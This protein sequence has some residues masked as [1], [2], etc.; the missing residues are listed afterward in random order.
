MVFILMEIIQLK[1]FFSKQFIK[2]N[3]KIVIEAVKQKNDTYSEFIL[4]MN[5]DKKDFSNNIEPIYIIPFAEKMLKDNNKR[6][7]NN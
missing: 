1:V 5:I 3:G 2:K 4:P 6:K 7:E